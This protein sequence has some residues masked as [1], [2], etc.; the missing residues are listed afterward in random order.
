MTL[1]NNP[2]Q[3]STGLTRRKAIAAALAAAGILFLPGFAA[4]ESA[5]RPEED[6]E[7]FVR[8][9]NEAAKV[10]H[11]KID[12]GQASFEEVVYFFQQLFLNVQDAPP[13]LLHDLEI[14]ISF[15]TKS[16]LN[17]E[18]LNTF[19]KVLNRWIGK[20]GFMPLRLAVFD[21]RLNMLEKIQQQIHLSP[22]MQQD[23]QQIFTSKELEKTSQKS[24]FVLRMTDS[25]WNGGAY[26]ASTNLIYI[27]QTFT[28]FMAAQQPFFDRDA[29]LRSTFAN[30]MAHSIL[31]SSL[32]FLMHDSRNTLLIPSEDHAFTHAEIHE[33][34]S[35]AASC[36]VS[37]EYIF[38]ALLSFIHNDD[39]QAQT[40]LGKLD[41]L[42]VAQQPAYGFSRFFFFR[43]M[44]QLPQF[45][46]IISEIQRQGNA[47]DGVNIFTLTSDIWQ[48]FSKD[49]L[50][51]IRVAYISKAQEMMT[52][53]RNRL[54]DER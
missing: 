21:G 46:E 9:V 3:A 48:L 1:S 20:Y 25:P 50:D 10:L 23:M 33:F 53:I 44:R 6:F 16:D 35:D 12:M 18:E 45:K 54:Q 19:Q 22:E 27:N 41:G 37:N 8:D 31:T 2:D 28:D 13:G 36:T 14:Y 43:Q 52:A 32:Q 17:E 49:D 39:Y 7:A 30:E 5:E 47:P 42:A 29:I 24:A 4:A 15:L 11:A 40:G 34:I 51:Q 26:D 38:S